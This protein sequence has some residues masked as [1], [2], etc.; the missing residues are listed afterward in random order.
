MAGTLLPGHLV[1]SELDVTLHSEGSNFEKQTVYFARISA[2][3]SESASRETG[4]QGLA[5]SN[6]IVT[7]VRPGSVSTSDGA[8]RISFPRDAMMIPHCHR[9][10]EKKASHPC[11]RLICLK[12]FQCAESLIAKT[13]MPLETLLR[14]RSAQGGAA[15]T[16]ELALRNKRGRGNRGAAKLTISFDA[17]TTKTDQG[18]RIFAMSCKMNANPAISGDS[19]ASA[20]DDGATVNM[21]VEYGG[22][23]RT[24][25][26]RRHPGAQSGMQASILFG[27]EGMLPTQWCLLSKTTAGTFLREAT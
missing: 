3:A 18:F 14:R 11:Y 20:C 1:V 13:S 16:H 25:G 12:E 23:T 5:P 10:K 9:T 4:A 6:A 15:F 27:R 21:T 24:T 22:V 8:T 19:V 7:P 2:N 17:T 26:L